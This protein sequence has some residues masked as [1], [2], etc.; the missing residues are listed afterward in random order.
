MDRN[1][2]H[3]RVEEDLT[4][5]KGKAKVFPKKRDPWARGYNHNRLKRD[6]SN[7]S[8]RTSEQM[9]SSVFKEPVY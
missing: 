2:E 1:D 4:Q 5:G 7:Q 3:K 6:F 9:V 8:S